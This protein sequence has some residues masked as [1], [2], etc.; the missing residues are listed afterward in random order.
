M[1]TVQFVAMAVVASH[2]VS[3]DER[4]L[5]LGRMDLSKVRRKIMEPKPEGQG[6]TETQALEAEKWYKRYLATIISFPEATRHVPNLPIDLFWHQH[7]LDTSAYRV[8]CAHV[9]GYFLDH[10]PYFGLNG[11]ATER[12]DSF[13][14]TNTLYQQIFGEDCTQMNQS[15]GAKGGNGGVACHGEGCAQGCANCGRDSRAPVAAGV[16]YSSPDPDTGSVGCSEGGASCKGGK[17]VCEISSLVGIGVNCNSGGSGT[18]CGQGC[19]RGK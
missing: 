3:T 10:Y 18:G 7:I 13:D 15:Y 2:G 1:R 17:G 14:V 8:D 5:R 9:L 11:D 4:L 19:S 16:A 12:D 6:W